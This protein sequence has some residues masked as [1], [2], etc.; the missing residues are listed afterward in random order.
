MRRGAHMTLQAYEVAGLTPD[1]R[2]RLI[3]KRAKEG[4]TVRIEAVEV[5][6]GAEIPLLL[7]FD[8]ERDVGRG[9]KE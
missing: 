8:S 1:E 3:A 9:R 2:R 7:F 4:K 6:D 5:R